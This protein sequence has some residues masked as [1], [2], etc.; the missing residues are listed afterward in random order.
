MVGLAN[1][2]LIYE[3]TDKL[4]EKPGMLDSFESVN[5]DVEDFDI[6]ELILKYLEHDGIVYGVKENGTLKAVFI[7]ELKSVKK[8]GKVLNFVN[9]YFT[10]DLSNALPGF[11][12]VIEENL[13]EKLAEKEFN[14]VIWNGK[15]ITS[16]SFVF[17]RESVVSFLACLLLGGVVGIPF[18][19]LLLGLIVGGAVGLFL[20]S[21]IRKTK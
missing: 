13:Q 20:G 10:E 11:V 2:Y 4:L 3:L 9:A 12:S 17:V 8:K 18:D 19:K 1:N 5:F 6:K 14:R 16:K 21:I 7:F 15:E